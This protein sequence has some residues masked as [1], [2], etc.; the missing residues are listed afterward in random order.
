MLDGCR[1]KCIGLAHVY[2]LGTEFRDSESSK[3]I[4]YDFC[5][6]LIE[7]RYQHTFLSSLNHGAIT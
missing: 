2:I 4:S 1:I 5:Q 3:R 6:I 7:A